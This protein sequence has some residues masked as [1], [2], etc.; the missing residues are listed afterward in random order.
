MPAGQHYIVMFIK[1]PV[2][3]RPRRLEHRFAD[4]STRLEYNNKSTL[5][6]SMMLAT[7]LFNIF[8]ESLSDIQYG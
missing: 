7:R 3:M 1:F 6:I 8:L 5:G 4:N 2:E